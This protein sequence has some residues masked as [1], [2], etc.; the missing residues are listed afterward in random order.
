[1]K[2]EYDE[3]LSSRTLPGNGH[4]L[5]MAKAKFEEGKMALRKKH[6][7][8]AAALFGQA[9]Y[10]DN[11]VPDYHFYLG[12]TL[13]N[14]KKLHEAEESVSKAL[15][16]DPFNSLYM[17]ELGHIYLELGLSLRAKNILEKAIKYDPSNERA[18]E[19]LQK[20]AVHS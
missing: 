1:M 3:S 10:L 18:T 13:E 14:E 15:K 2:K 9:V 11:S 4:N 6:Y 19:G 5:D 12:L 16:L 17:A 7:A 8:D 20:M